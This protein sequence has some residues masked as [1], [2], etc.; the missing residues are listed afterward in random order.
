MALAESDAKPAQAEPW[1]AFYQRAQGLRQREILGQL[2]EEGG[3]KALRT[4]AVPEARITAK[5][6]GALKRKLLKRWGRPVAA[7]RRALEP[8]HTEADIQ[9]YEPV[10][11][12]PDA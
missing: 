6:L 11:G 12:G 3:I 2:P 5:E 1:E 7:M 9:P 8:E 10:E 4:H